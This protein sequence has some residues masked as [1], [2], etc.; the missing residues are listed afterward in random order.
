MPRPTDG[1]WYRTTIS[2]QV[3]VSGGRWSSAKAE[4]CIIACARLSVGLPKDG[5]PRL[6]R[7]PAKVMIRPNGG[8]GNTQ[9]QKSLA[10][11]NPASPLKRQKFSCQFA[12]DLALGAAGRFRLG[13]FDDLAYLLP[14]GDAGFLNRGADQLFQ[15]LRGERLGQK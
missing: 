3:E 12:D 11:A 1:F 5:R 8:S 6:G 14:A 7:S 9:S 15:L 13:G 10:D 2:F 4:S